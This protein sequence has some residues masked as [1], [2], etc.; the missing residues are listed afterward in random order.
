M[1]REESAESNEVDMSGD[2]NRGSGGSPFC[3][4]VPLPTQKRDVGLIGRVG[5]L[6]SCGP[7]KRPTG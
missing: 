4:S 3:Y 7:L 1:G 6:Q 2:C 5:A